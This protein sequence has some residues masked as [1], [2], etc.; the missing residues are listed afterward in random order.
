MIDSTA[1]FELLSH[2][3]LW[4]RLLLLPLQAGPGSPSTLWVAD[5]VGDKVQQYDVTIPSAN[6]IR[7]VGSKGALGR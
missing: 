3:C 2:F 4:L 6:L 5:I 7:E 1:R